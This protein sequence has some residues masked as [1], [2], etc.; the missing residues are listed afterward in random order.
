MAAGT[1]TLWVGFFG[2][3]GGSVSLISQD[4]SVWTFE[5]ARVCLNTT[6]SAAFSGLTVFLY[7]VRLRDPVLEDN[8]NA[9]IGGLVAAC[10]TSSIVEPYAAAIIGQLT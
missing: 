10:A 5:V 6:L 7:N 1:I 9:V 3:N 2:F 4:E 8:F